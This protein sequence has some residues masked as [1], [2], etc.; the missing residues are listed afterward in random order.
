MFIGTELIQA[1]SEQFEKNKCL[2]SRLD[3]TNSFGTPMF[4]GTELILARFEQI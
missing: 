3:S 4:F 1:Q 2:R